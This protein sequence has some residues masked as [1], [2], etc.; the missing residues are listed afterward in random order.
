M[1]VPGVKGTINLMGACVWVNAA[2]GV[3][4]ARADVT[5]KALASHAKTHWLKNVLRRMI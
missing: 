3:P 5:V 2:G 4:C 1:P